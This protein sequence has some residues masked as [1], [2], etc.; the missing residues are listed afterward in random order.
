MTYPSPVGAFEELQ[1]GQTRG[2]STPN[3]VAICGLCSDA[4]SQR[5]WEW[6]SEPAV[7]TDP[8][9]AV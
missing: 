5:A 8:S 7:G 2:D 4:V 6:K 9:A 3:A 1:E